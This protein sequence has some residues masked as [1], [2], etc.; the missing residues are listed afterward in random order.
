MPVCYRAEQ[1]GSL[2]RPPELLQ[3][4]AQHAEGTLPL[5][6]LRLREDEA[7]T[8]VLAKQ[9]QIGIDVVTDGEMRRGSWLTDMADGA[10]GLVPQRGGAGGEGRRGARVRHS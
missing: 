3:A 6:E 5:A 10:W 4:R 1:V 8:A 7:I 2:L 9:R